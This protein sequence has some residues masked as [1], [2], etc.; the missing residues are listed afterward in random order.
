MIDRSC[1]TDPPTVS[2]DYINTPQI[3]K[4]YMIYKGEKVQNCFLG[5]KQEY[6]P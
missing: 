5:I 1:M 3:F 2:V 4:G 6:V